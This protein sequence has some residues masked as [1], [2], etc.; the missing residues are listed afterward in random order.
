MDSMKLNV[1]QARAI[2]DAMERHDT[3][4]TD[5]TLATAYADVTQEE[6]NGDRIIF[7][8]FEDTGTRRAFWHDGTDVTAEYE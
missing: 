5:P 3:D 7:V 4:K 8:R 6:R 2:A 1:W